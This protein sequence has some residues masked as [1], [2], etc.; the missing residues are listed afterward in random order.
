M[1]GRCSF[2]PVS[3]SDASHEILEARVAVETVPLR[4]HLHQIHFMVAGLNAPR[5]RVSP[6]HFVGADGRGRIGFAEDTTG[7]I[8]ALSAG[9]W[10]VLGRID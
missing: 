4:I 8:T 9:S 5:L 1:T 6:L 2:A 7:R 3:E 10:K